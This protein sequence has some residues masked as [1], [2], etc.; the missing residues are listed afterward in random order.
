MTYSGIASEMV[1]LG[2]FKLSLACW[3]GQAGVSADLGSV[4]GGRG[5]SPAGSMAAGNLLIG[6]RFLLSFLLVSRAAKH[7]QASAGDREEQL[8]VISLVCLFTFL[9]VNADLSLWPLCISQDCQGIL[10]P[11]DN[12]ML[13]VR[14]PTCVSSAR[15]GPVLLCVRARVCVCL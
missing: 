10:L 11:A 3:A 1:G 14:F 12:W 15:V 6:V 9:I 4:V 8:N 5:H 13:T 7:S 2:L